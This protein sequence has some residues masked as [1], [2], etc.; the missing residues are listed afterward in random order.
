MR[1]FVSFSVL[2]SMD[3]YL[4]YDIGKKLKLQP[5]ET[6]LLSP[7]GC[8]ATTFD[9][10]IMRHLQVGIG[11][12]GQVIVICIDGEEFVAKCY[13]SGLCPLDMS[14]IEAK[15]AEIRAYKALTAM[16]GKE[17]PKFYGEF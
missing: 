8:S 13:D 2:V 14:C 11:R 6:S 3:G 15:N 4:R 17:I 16:Q 10:E 5:C 9:A 1:P 12:R 7:S